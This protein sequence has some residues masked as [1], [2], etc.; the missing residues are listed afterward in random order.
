MGIRCSRRL[1]VGM[2][3]F[4]RVGIISQNRSRGLRMDSI[5]GIWGDVFVR[6]EKDL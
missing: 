5:G 4:R 1:Q 3:M 2:A 6:L